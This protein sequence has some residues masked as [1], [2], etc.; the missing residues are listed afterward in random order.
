MNHVYR[1]VWS[2]AHSAWVAVAE[3]VK[4]RGKRSSGTFGAAKGAKPL[5]L[6]MLLL[7]SALALASLNALALDTAALPTGAK[8]VGGPDVGPDGM[9]GRLTFGI[10]WR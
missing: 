5:N 7:S 8:V 2:E 1:F 9:Y 10:G 3:T 4:G 6:A